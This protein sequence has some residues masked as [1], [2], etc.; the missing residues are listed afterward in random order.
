MTWQDLLTP[1]LLPWLALLYKSRDLYRDPRNPALWALQFAFFSLGMGLLV[2]IPPIYHWID[3]LVGVPHIAR[4]LAHAFALG[5][6][7]GLQIL[8][9][10]LSHP[11]AEAGRKA[12]F[13]YAALTISLAAM[14]ALFLAAPIEQESAEFITEYA[15]ASLIAGY[16][17][18]YCAYLEY[19]LFDICRLAQRYSHHARSG[20][21]RLGLRLIAV[22]SALAL[23]YPA[24]KAAYV[25][26]RQLGLGVP[27]FEKSISAVVITLSVLLVV[28]GLT[29][30]G[31]GPRVASIRGAIRDYRLY[32]AIRPLWQALAAG[33]PAMVT[34]RPRV[35]PHAEQRL[36]RQ[37]I[38]VRD[39]L[40]A[41]RPYHDPAVRR[42]ACEVGRRVGVEGAEL[43]ALADAAA[44]SAAVAARRENRD[45]HTG[46]QEPIIETPPGDDLLVEARRLARVS[47]AFT[48]SPHMAA[49][50]AALSAGHADEQAGSGRAVP[51]S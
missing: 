39:E 38:E 14:T 48:G 25:G 11:K 31:W 44:I 5:N 50:A 22:G 34:M 35:L 30:P 8:L 45:R 16:M 37:V 47:R 1:V 19:S 17:L 13:R 36:Y 12:R 26:A 27:D 28:T 32:Q 20:H 49:V 18:V 10:Y 2:R 6:G 46:N 42:V 40:L 23:L 41:L 7:L 15:D 51:S 21:L 24:N 4:L 29:V 3:G 43:Y 33:S 9:L